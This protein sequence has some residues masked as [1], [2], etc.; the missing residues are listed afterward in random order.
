MWTPF[1]TL[2]AV[3]TAYHGIMNRIWML[4][5]LSSSESIFLYSHLSCS[6]DCL[7]SL[8]LWHH[9]QDITCRHTLHLLLHSFIAECSQYVSESHGMI[10]SPGYPSTIYQ[11]I[12]CTWFIHFQDGKSIKLELLNMVIEPGCTTKR[13]WSRWEMLFEILVTTKFQID[14]YTYFRTYGHFGSLIKPH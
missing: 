14:V 8:Y 2:T 6:R 4:H 1:K 12:D 11:N 13:P 5:L 7:Y 3:E 9:E 10:R